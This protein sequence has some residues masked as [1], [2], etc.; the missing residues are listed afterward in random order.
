MRGGMPS[1]PYVQAAS[2]LVFPAP[3][4]RSPSVWLS[5]LVVGLTVA[6]AGAATGDSASQL[7]QTGVVNLGK[8]PAL[9]RSVGASGAPA[10][11]TNASPSRQAVPVRRG[12]PALR[13][14]P[15]PPP[16]P[17]GTHP[18][19]APA[20]RTSRDGARASRR[21]GAA[22][23]PDPR[24]REGR[25]HDLPRPGGHPAKH[26]ARGPHRHQGAGRL[27]GGVRGTRVHGY[28]GAGLRAVVLPWR[29]Q[30]HLDRPARRLRRRE[31]PTEETQEVSGVTFPLADPAELA[32]PAGTARVLRAFGVRPR[33]R[34][35]QHF[36]IS[37]RVLD[38][39]LAEAEPGPADLV[40]EVG[41]GLGTLTVALAATGAQVVA[42]EVDERL[43]PILRAATAGFP[44]VR[45]VHG[46]IMALDLVELTVGGAA[47]SPHSPPQPVVSPPPEVDSAVLRLDVLPRR[48]VRVRDEA[49]FFTV[50]RA[51][52]GQRRKMLRSAL[53]DARPGVTAE[54]VR[55]AC[56]RAGIDPRRRG[57]T[58]GLEEFGSL[59]DA[60]AA[61]L[62]QKREG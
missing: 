48:R 53:V 29:G 6:L 51:A 18:G 52:F 8:R 56:E 23:P 20:S 5:P 10:A 27:A 60:L 21:K 28:G 19:P 12:R 44:R 24:R 37:R 3:S 46:D 4:R 15:P 32:T 36:L 1:P 58:M 25:L 61:G 31:G 13:G 38:R 55:A 50:V 41:A 2:V 54:R 47:P 33:K 57:E 62:R 26:T 34:F 39:L 30:H 40:L 16:R 7:R 35:G 49:L 42:V 9:V 14:E 17:G 59:A 11:A 45:L 22:L 43:I